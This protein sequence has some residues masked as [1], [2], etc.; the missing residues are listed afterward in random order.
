M[1]IF[2]TIPAG[3]HTGTLVNAKHG[4][5]INLLASLSVEIDSYNK[6]LVRDYTRK[7][8]E[9]RLINDLTKIFDSLGLDNLEF[10]TKEQAISWLD[11]VKPKVCVSLDKPNMIDIFV[12]MPV[13]AVEEEREDI[14]AVAVPA[15]TQEQEDIE[16]CGGQVLKYDDHYFKRII[17]RNVRCRECTEQGELLPTFCLM[18]SSGYGHRWGLT[19]EQAQNKLQARK[20]SKPISEC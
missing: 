3:I 18:P 2:S 5:G 19:F 17:S 15:E 16:E 13:A 1:S 8:G 7:M 14:P 4:N 6:I 9:A 20:Q 11:E 12:P 10:Q